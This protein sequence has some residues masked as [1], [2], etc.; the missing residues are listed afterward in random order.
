ME[1]LFSFLCFS[2]CFLFSKPDTVHHGFS[3]DLWNFFSHFGKRIRRLPL[4]YLALFKIIFHYKK[5]I[6]QCLQCTSIFYSVM[7]LQSLGG[8]RGE[9]TYYIIYN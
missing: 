8:M 6:L 4:F 3:L 2:C 5:A 1:F 9:R 7:P